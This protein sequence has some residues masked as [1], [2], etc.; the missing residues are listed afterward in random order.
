MNVHFDS[1]L[2][3]AASKNGKGQG[4]VY[5]DA[6]RFAC[7]DLRLKVAFTWKWSIFWHFDK[8]GLRNGSGENCDGQQGN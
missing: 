4:S 6:L 3:E 8:L 1:S 2:L 5:N 7:F